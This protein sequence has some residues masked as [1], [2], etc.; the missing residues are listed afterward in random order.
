M[1]EVKEITKTIIYKG[2]LKLGYEDDSTTLRISIYP[3]AD[4]MQ[5]DIFLHG[6]KLKISIFISDKR[7]IKII[8]IKEWHLTYEGI[9]EAEYYQYK[10]K[11]IGHRW[12]EEKIEITYEISGT[13]EYSPSDAQLG[14]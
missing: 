7:K 14:L 2:F 11:N 10:S 4:L 9:A 12:T 6:K 3:L 5:D 13:G 1:E 8:D